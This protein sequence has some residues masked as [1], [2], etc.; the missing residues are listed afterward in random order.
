MMYWCVDPLDGTK[1]FVKKRD[2][3]TVNIALVRDGR[4]V[5]GVI[6]I[7]AQDVLYCAAVNAG[8]WRVNHASEVADPRGDEAQPLPVRL[9][10][11]DALLT[12][13]ASRSHPSAETEAFLQRHGITEV[14]RHGSSLKIC[15]VAEGAADV[16][17]RFGP[18]CLWDTAAGAA[19]ARVADCA[20]VATD[21]QPLE[22]RVQSGLKHN[23]FIVYRPE[24]IEPEFG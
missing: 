11:E 12:A 18:T 3:Y 24:R 2:E 1:E 4:P 21:G 6:Y 8:A 9:P 19:I 10:A 16:Y 5:L 22:Y 15:A 14:L 7:P 13:V 17:P 20:V 23:G